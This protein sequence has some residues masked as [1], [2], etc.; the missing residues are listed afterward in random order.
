[1]KGIFIHKRLFAGLVEVLDA[2]LMAFYA[3]VR[4]NARRMTRLAVTLLPLIMLLVGSCKTSQLPAA[5]GSNAGPDQFRI[6][7]FPDRVNFKGVGYYPAQGYISRAQK[8]VTGDPQS[9]LMLTDEEITY[10]FGKPAVA[11]HDAAAEIW[12]YRTAACVVD[13]FFYRDKLEKEDKGR[14][15]YV[16]VRLKNNVASVSP[17]RQTRCLEHVIGDAASTL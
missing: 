15:S 16:D 11:R 7:L 10:L 13:F 1:M 12:Q 4:Q 17:S 8:F 6:A 2:L 14:V 5:Y 9:L 3:H